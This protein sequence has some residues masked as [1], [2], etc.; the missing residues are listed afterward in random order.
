MSTEVA[1][2]VESQ[3]AEQSPGEDKN[4]PFRQQAAIIARKKEAKAEQFGELRSQLSLVEEELAA[5]QK[6]LQ[7]VAGE[8]V[9]R[10]D[11]LKKY[12]AKLR[13]KGALYKKQKAQLAAL[14]T[15]AGILTRTLEVLASQDQSVLQALV[16]R[17]RL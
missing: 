3:L 10:G 8:A 1:Q 13:G 15:E 9:L 17:F 2:M 14:K 16:C 5:K 6:Q 4:A 11:D 12:V 7:E